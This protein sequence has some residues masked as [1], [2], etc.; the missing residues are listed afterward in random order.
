MATKYR[1]DPT[2]NAPTLSGPDDARDFT[3]TSGRR[4]TTP[5]SPE[6]QATSRPRS[7]PDAVVAAARTGGEMLDAGAAAPAWSA[8]SWP[9]RGRH[10]R[11]AGRVARGCSKRARSDRCLPRPARGRPHRSAGPA[12]RPLRRRRLRQDADPRAPRARG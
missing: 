1:G 6:T 12:G 9:A 7:P 4:P 8:W 5:T 11:Q 2:W 10:D 3:T